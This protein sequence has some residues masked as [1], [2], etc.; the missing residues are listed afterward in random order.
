MEKTIERLNG[1]HYDAVM[2]NVTDAFG[3]DNLSKNV[4]LFD[5][6]KCD[7]AIT[8]SVKDNVFNFGYLD[9]PISEISGWQSDVPDKSLCDCRKIHFLYGVD[10]Q[11][12]T[13]LK[14]E[15]ELSTFLLK[16]YVQIL[17][18]PTTLDPVSLPYSTI[19]RKFVRLTEDFTLYDLIIEDRKHLR[20]A[21]SSLFQICSVDKIKSKLVSLT[22]GLSPY[23]FIAEDRKH[24]RTVSIYSADHR[25]TDDE[26]IATVKSH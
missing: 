10:G 20:A 25:I 26:L 9:C 5:R 17:L 12:P 1:V 23:D 22:E 13:Y 8:F 7:E 3:G 19:R 4:L 2:E 18:D 21:S 11:Y 14:A 24:L 6:H 15:Y 16:E